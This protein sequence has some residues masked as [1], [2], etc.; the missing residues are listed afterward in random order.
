MKR[1]FFWFAVFVLFLIYLDIALYLFGVR[2]AMGNE[3]WFALRIYEFTISIA[4]YIQSRKLE[5]MLDD[6][7]QFFLDKGYK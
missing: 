2:N 7:E 1:P 4:V 6:K 3:Q 5:G